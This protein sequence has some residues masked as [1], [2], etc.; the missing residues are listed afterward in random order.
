MSEKF[1]IFGIVA[2]I[3]GKLMGRRRFLPS[4]RYREVIQGKRAA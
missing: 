2:A 1:K 4:A 3:V